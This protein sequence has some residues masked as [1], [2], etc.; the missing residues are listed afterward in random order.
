M[1]WVKIC[2]ITRAQDARA[3][4]AAGADAIGLVFYAPSPRAL[5]PD[6][7]AAIAG[8]VPAGLL[9]IG[10]FVDAPLAAMVAAVRR[11]PLDMI[12]LHGD[13]PPEIAA[14]LPVPVIRAVRTPGHAARYAGHPAAAL[15]VDGAAPGFYGGTGTAADATL[16]AAVP[17][18]R[19]L[20]LAG[21]LTPENIAARVARF[22]PW[23]VD[24]AS[25]VES[26]PGVK[27][28]ARIVAFVAAAKAS[29]ALPEARTA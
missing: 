8:A 22:A 20:I 5:T 28:S 17:R 29:S 16:M 24:T 4:A 14:L 9:K 7:A 21:G 19:R 1:T 23:G 3:A 13:E 15:L 18:G 10:V 12:Q 25:G 11:V 27:D 6:A 26:A 2:G